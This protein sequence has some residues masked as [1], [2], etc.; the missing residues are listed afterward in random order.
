[1]SSLTGEKAKALTASNTLN[2]NQ[3]V[4]SFGT[5]RRRLQNCI[6]STMVNAPI[7]RAVTTEKYH[8]R[9]KACEL[10]IKYSRDSGTNNAIEYSAS[11]KATS[12]ASQ[13]D[14]PAVLITNRQCA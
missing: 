6:N 3:M 10:L 13:S 2:S 7:A 8:C 1:M 12:A 11:V 14:T 5:L 9:V 4:N